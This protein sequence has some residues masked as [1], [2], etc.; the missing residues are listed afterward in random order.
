MRN[1]PLV[2]E[3]EHNDTSTNAD[4]RDCSKPLTVEQACSADPS[5]GA[6]RK[7]SDVLILG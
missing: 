4:F 2:F 5:S 3:S 7:F 6:L 1:L